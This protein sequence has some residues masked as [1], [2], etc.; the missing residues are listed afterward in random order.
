MEVE[1]LNGDLIRFIATVDAGD[2][3]IEEGAT[4]SFFDGSTFLGTAPVDPATGQAVFDH[5]FAERGEHQIRAVFNG[6]EKKDGEG[7]ITEVLEPYESAPVTLD[8]REHDVVIEEPGDNPG[9]NPGDGSGSC[10]ASGSSSGGF[11]ASAIGFLGNLGIIGTF[12]MSIFGLHAIQ[13]PAAQPRSVRRAP[14]HHEAGRASS[15]DGPRVS[16]PHPA[17]HTNRN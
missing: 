1:V 12:L 9:D 16:V 13:H 2:S 4:V 15:R 3:T 6:Q 14:P 5:R 8:V 10:G 7:V 17:R 11:L